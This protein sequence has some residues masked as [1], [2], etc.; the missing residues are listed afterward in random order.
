MVFA[1]I[2]PAW[3]CSVISMSQSRTC[4]SVISPSGTSARWGRSRLRPWVS[5]SSS[6]PSVRYALFSAS[7]A[8]QKRAKDAWAP[9][10]ASWREALAGLARSLAGSIPA[11]CRDAAIRLWDRHAP[12]HAL[13]C[14]VGGHATAPGVVG[15]VLLECLD[16][17]AK[18]GEFVGQGRLVASA[19]PP[20]WR[21]AARRRSRVPTPRRRSAVSAA[22]R[23]VPADDPT[24]AARIELDAHDTTLVGQLLA[25]PPPLE[26]CHENL[27]HPPLATPTGTKKPRKC[28]AFTMRRRG[29]EPPPGYPGPGP[30]PCNPGVRS[31]LCVHIVQNVRE[32]GR[33]GRNG[34][35]GCCRG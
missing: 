4:R 6:A 29:L 13:P 25:A 7:H 20:S 11:A 10:D 1:E 35:S 23:L 27:P 14:R 34:R 19:V 32:S 21:R 16:A 33:I 8:S 3:C 28:G 9:G 12:A 15:Q 2:A 5:R 18:L 24:L 22:V 31:V 26:S 17:R 30:Q